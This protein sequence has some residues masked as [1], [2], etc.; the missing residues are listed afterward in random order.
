MIAGVQ[1]KKE[2][3]KKLVKDLK[4]LGAKMSAVNRQS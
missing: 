3:K 2:N 4:R 1:L